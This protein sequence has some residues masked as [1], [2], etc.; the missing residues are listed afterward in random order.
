MHAGLTGTRS[1][2]LRGSLYLSFLMGGLHQRHQKHTR[3][4]EHSLSI[5]TEKILKGNNFKGFLY[6]LMGIFSLSDKFAHFL[7]VNCQKCYDYLASVTLSLQEV[8]LYRNPPTI[9]W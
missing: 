8:K 5:N 6:H 3:N 1:M 7:F 2:I 4:T 9:G